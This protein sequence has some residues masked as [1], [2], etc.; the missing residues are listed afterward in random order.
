MWSPVRTMNRTVRRRLV[1][2]PW[3]LFPK[4]FSVGQVFFLSSLWRGHDCRTWTVVCTSCPQGQRADFSMPI[5]IMWLRSLQWPVLSRNIMVFSW[6]N[7]R[8]RE[9]C[10][11][12]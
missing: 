5:F 6:R 11:G 1:I 10:L 9:S 3:S 7:N 2:V 12:L 8:Q 4:D